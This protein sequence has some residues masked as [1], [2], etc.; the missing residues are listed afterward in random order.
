MPPMYVY[1]CKCGKQA[2]E[3]RQIDE[4]DDAPTHCGKAMQ[5]LIVGT[6]VTPDIQPY[7]SQVDGSWITSRSRHREHLKRHNKIEIGNE[8]AH[9]LKPRPRIKLDRDARKRAISEQLSKYG[10]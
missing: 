4:R 5:R 7:Q 8:L 1:E 3:F 2:E 6:R 10:I 9:V